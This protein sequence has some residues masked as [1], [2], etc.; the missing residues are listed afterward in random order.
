MIFGIGFSGDL[1]GKGY[2]L[3]RHRPPLPLPFGVDAGETLVDKDARTLDGGSSRRYGGVAE[4]VQR[5]FMKR[6]LNIR[7]GLALGL[8]QP[9][10]GHDF[11]LR[12]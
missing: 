4:T 11:V 2:D 5:T 7:R 12:R 8:E 3:D 9:L 10:L 1:R 6:H